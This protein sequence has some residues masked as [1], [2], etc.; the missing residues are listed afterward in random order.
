MPHCLDVVI[1]GL[2]LSSAWGNG[3]ATTYRALLRGLHQR[4]HRVLFLEQDQPWYAAHRDEAAP[5]YCE[6]QLYSG[7]EDLRRRFAERIAAADAVIVGSYVNRGAEVCDWVLEEACAVRAFYAIDTPVTLASLEA[8]TCEYLRREQIAAFDLLLSFTG[9]PTLQ[10]LQTAFGAQRAEALYCSVDVDQYAPRACLKNL[11]L[12][13]MG[14]Y[15]ADRQEGLERLLLEPARRLPTHAFAVCG[16]QYPHE[17]RW[18]AN[19]RWT[20]H[21]PPHEHVEFYCR[22]RC[23]LNLTRTEMRRRGFSPSVRLFEAA[24]CQAPIIS[25]DWPGLA[26]LFEPEKEIIIAS[27]TDE[28]VERLAYTSDQDLQRLARNARERVLQ[29]HSGRCRAA[30]LEGYLQAARSQPVLPFAAASTKNTAAELRA[31]S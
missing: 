30:E 13:Y 28:V 8:G 24:A 26:E 9:G 25:D 5:Q 7:F 22:Q 10:Y 2:T 21:C 29:A 20:Q 11:D 6:L 19:V 4:G 16:A 14:T 27:S 23:T 31:S 17:L 1:I 12:G 18:P 3:H 15:S